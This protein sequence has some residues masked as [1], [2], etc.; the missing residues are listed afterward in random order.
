MT[1]AILGREERPN[2][3]GSSD[4]YSAVGASLGCLVMPPPSPTICAFSM[5]SRCR[6]LRASAISTFAL[7]DLVPPDESD[8]A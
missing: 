3:Q 2:L 1:V 4:R 8:P 6:R 7:T 5:R